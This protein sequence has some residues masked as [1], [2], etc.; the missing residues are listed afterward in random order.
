MSD[1]IS[2]ELAQTS[3]IA[4]AESLLKELREVFILGRSVDV[5]ASKVEKVDTAIIQLLVSLKKSLDSD[6][7]QLR[8]VEPSEHFKMAIETSGL[9]SFFEL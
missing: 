4:Q 7:H 1:S 5:D 6:H 8:I 9:N 2:L 3:T